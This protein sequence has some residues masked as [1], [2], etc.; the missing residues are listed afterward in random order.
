MSMVMFVPSLLANISSNTFRNTCF[1]E[2]ESPAEIMIACSSWKFIKTFFTV[3][4]TTKS[5][6]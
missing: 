4:F 5:I 3:G 2:S 6:N 1:M